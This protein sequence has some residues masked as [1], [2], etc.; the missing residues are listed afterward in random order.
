[1]FNGMLCNRSESWLAN[2]KDVLPINHFAQSQQV[3]HIW[4]AGSYER[5]VFI[6]LEGEHFL[7]LATAY[8]AKCP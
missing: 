1:M 7:L 5:D 6:S 4:E 3:D 2:Q 8:I